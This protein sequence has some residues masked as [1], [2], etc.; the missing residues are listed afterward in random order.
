MVCLFIDLKETNNK[1]TSIFL[2]CFRCSIIEF[3]DDETTPPGTPPP[4]YKIKSKSS[5]GK[6]PMVPKR[7]YFQSTNSQQC[8][9]ESVQ[10]N[11]NAHNLSEHDEFM[12]AGDNVFNSSTM[13]A[14]SFGSS[15]GG[16]NN[17]ASGAQANAMQRQIISMEDD[18]VGDD[19]ELISGK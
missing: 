16:G 14:S 8:S 6:H 19:S 7:N 3:I 5:D 17:N 18:E 12:T 1:F 10:S 11:A 4:P 9:N 2:I 15:G 13:S